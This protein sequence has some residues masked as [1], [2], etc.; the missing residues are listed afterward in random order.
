MWP[1]GRRLNQTRIT[2]IVFI[3]CLVLGLSHPVEPIRKRYVKSDIVQQYC[4]LE[5]LRKFPEIYRNF[6]GNVQKFITTKTF[7]IA[8]H[9][10]TI[11]LALL[12]LI[13]V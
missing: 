4:E 10:V 5:N 12:R 3:L 6:H 9:L 8:V 13:S 11:L 2:S 1:R 7:E